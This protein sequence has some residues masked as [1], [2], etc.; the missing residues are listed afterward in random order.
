[1]HADVAAAIG[2]SLTPRPQET[3]ADNSHRL[4]EADLARFDMLEAMLDEEIAAAQAGGGHGGGASVLGGSTLSRAGSVLGEPMVAGMHAAALD[5][6]A[7]AGA[8]FAGEGMEGSAALQRPPAQEVMGARRDAGRTSWYR[9]RHIRMGSSRSIEAVIAGED[10]GEEEEDDEGVEMESVA[11]IGC[12][13]FERG[14]GEDMEAFRAA[15]ERAALEGDRESGEGGARSCAA[16]GPGPARVLHE[17]RDPGKRRERQVTYPVGRILRL[18]P[19]E[20]LL[21][22]AGDSVAA[23]SVRAVLQRAASSGSAGVRQADG[24]SR[25]SEV[26][27]GRSIDAGEL[28]PLLGNR[29]GGAGDVVVPPAPAYVVMDHVPQTAFRRIKL[30]RTMLSD[31]YLRRYL[32]AMSAAVEYCQ[33]RVREAG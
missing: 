31:H 30:C 14:L 9:P 7:A 33:A 20:A 4:C 18:L 26:A 29:E 2:D 12:D 16:M 19:A 28:R 22:S 3:D 25:S 5:F 32:A 27:R 23:G 13:V 1:M 11:G 15:Y 17:G 10:S 24:P 21:R 8:G 6:A